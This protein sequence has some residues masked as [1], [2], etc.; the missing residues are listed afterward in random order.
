MA[1]TIVRCKNTEGLKGTCDYCYS[2]SELSLF[3]VDFELNRVV[4][5]SF[6]T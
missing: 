6:L 3:S 5:L 4:L 1:T 2:C